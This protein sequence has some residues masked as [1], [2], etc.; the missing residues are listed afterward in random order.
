MGTEACRRDTPLSVGDAIQID[1]AFSE[2]PSFLPTTGAVLVLYEDEDV[3]VVSKKAGQI[4]YPDRLDGTGTVVND[5]LGYYQSQGI[6]GP[7]R[8]LHR[9]DQDTTGCLLIAKHLLAHSFLTEKWNHVDVKRTYLA[10][11]DGIFT[12]PSG[13]IDSPIAKDRHKNAY[14]VSPTG[15]SAKTEYKILKQGAKRALVEL[16]LSTGRTHQ[17]RIHLASIGHPVAGDG[18]YGGSVI[19]G[20]FALHSYHL[21]FPHPRDGRSVEIL[22]PMPSR[23]DTL[24]SRE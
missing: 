1:L 20:A 6:P 4:I 3:L 12:R 16:T 11:A 8:Y 24:L 19:P 15:A 2:G 22:D 14:R 21:T 13:V 17:I 7:V 10:V 23:Y 5:V 9:L 18:L